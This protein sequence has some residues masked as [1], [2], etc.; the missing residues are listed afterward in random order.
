MEQATTLQELLPIRMRWEPVEKI[1]Q[2][3][4]VQLMLRVIAYSYEWS[5]SGR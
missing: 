1:L 4:G 3:N 2:L 5:F